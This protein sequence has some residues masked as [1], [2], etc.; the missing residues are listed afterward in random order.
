MSLD[1]NIFSKT[2]YFIGLNNLIKLTYFNDLLTLMKQN[3]HDNH[4]EFV[5]LNSI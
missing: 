5:G 4:V 3:K 2:I 1:R